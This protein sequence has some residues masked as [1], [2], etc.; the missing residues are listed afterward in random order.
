M[1]AAGSAPYFMMMVEPAE[2]ALMRPSLGR[3]SIRTHLTTIAQG[4]VLLM[5]IC[6]MN[7]LLLTTEPPRT[8]VKPKL[9]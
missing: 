5:G 6:L 2:D 3:E 8:I 7:I 9:V 4:H 1:D